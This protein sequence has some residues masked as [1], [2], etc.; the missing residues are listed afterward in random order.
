[1]PRL[2]DLAVGD[3]VRLTFDG[4]VAADPNNRARKVVHIGDTMY[5]PVY[6]RPDAVAL[7]SLTK[8]A[9]AWKVG[10]VV[11]IAFANGTQAPRYTYVRGA[12]TWP[13]ENGNPLTD[14]DVDRRFDEGKVIHLVRD[15]KPVVE[16]AMATGG[17]L[18][19]SDLTSSAIRPGSI[20][21]PRSPRVLYPF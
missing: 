6:L 11:S 16:P 4:K 18:T 8:K 3:R 20:T 12:S 1:M 21:R 14:A 19:A 15:G 9:P 10:D 7:G 2:N 17:T 13:G 5:S